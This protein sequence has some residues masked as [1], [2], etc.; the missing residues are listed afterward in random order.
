MAVT[1]GYWAILS[2]NVDHHIPAVG[3]GYVVPCT[4]RLLGA[5][6]CKPL[7]FVYESNRRV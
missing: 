5:N 6:L 3:W 1:L 4:E 2:H 7:V